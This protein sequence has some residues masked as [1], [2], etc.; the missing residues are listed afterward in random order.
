MHACN[1]TIQ[2]ELQNAM[3]SQNTSIQRALLLQTQTIAAQQAQLA[4]LCQAE[5]VPH[6]AYPY[7]TYMNS[8]QQAQITETYRDVH[9]Y[10]REQMFGC[11]RNNAALPSSAPKPKPP[12]PKPPTYPPSNNPISPLLNHNKIYF[13]EKY[14]SEDKPKRSF[15]AFLKSLISFFRG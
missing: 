13:N 12:E 2:Q 4:K 15:F 6:P 8:L 14:Y 10:I 7:P 3:I 5:N 9:E 1:T 11:C